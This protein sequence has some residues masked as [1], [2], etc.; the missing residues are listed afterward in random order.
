M[1][2]LLIL[3]CTIEKVVIFSI[4]FL[5]AAYLFL[6]PASIYTATYSFSLMCLSTYFQCLCSVCLFACLSIYLLSV[7]PSIY[8]YLRPA[9]RLTV[10]SSS[11]SILSTANRV[12]FFFLNRLEIKTI[13]IISIN[14]STS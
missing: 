10:K 5:D 6:T 11:T 8:L 4:I 14:S 13:R 3:N 2:C 1:H 12:S 9:C 7:L